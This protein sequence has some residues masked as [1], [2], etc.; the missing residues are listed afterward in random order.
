MIAAWQNQAQISK[1]VKSNL[2]SRASNLNSKELDVFFKLELENSL[3]WELELVNIPGW[4]PK[5]ELEN[6]LL[7]Y[8]LFYSKWL[9]PWS[10]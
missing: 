9:A 3:S 2:L 8:P 5:F 10:K 4:E 1:R 6:I 7:N